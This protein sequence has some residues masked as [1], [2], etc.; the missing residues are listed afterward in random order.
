[1]PPGSAIDLRP[2][3]SRCAGLCC[4]AAAFAASADFAIDKAAGEACPNLE[5]DFR[6]GIHANL[7]RAGFPGCVAYDCFGAGQQV[8]QVTFHGR[9]WRSAPDEAGAM[10]E[11]FATMRALHEL[12]WYLREALSLPAT[13]R[14]AGGL[15]DA[16][17]RVVSLTGLPAGELAAVDVAGL[18][19]AVGA[20]LGPASEAARATAV[21]RARTDGRGKGLDR[22]GA[23]LAGRDLAGADLRAVM[24]RG[25]TLIGAN[26]RGADL[27]HADLAGAD[28]RGADLSGADLRDALFVAQSQLDA[29]NGDPA[30]RLP[31]SR[32]RPAHW[33]TPPT[34]VASG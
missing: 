11:A 15:A 29:A 3:C 34:T 20:L 14:L 33:L 31:P 7:R 4:V 17:S 10:F 8:T 21:A 23:D 19:A 6:C 25:A 9:D 18:Q 22:R 24:L 30:T 12:A 5:A 27:R 32:T 28:L 16:L 1:M 13:A 2:D 26:L